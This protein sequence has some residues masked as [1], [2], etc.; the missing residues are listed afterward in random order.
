MRFWSE[1]PPILFSGVH[2]YVR[3]RKMDRKHFKPIKPQRSFLEWC[4]DKRLDLLVTLGGMAAVLLATI[5]LH[6]FAPASW[7]KSAKVVVIPPGK[8]FHEV[9]RILED[10]G[11]IR[12]R[13][14][15]Y[16]LARIEG[17][18]SRVKA[19][20][21]EVHT[22]MPPREVLSKLVR[23]EVIQ[24]PVTIPE[25]YNL[26]QIG[27]VLEQAK[28]C[29]KKIFLEKVRDPAFIDSLGL[30]G[31]SLEGYL[32]P[33]TYNL[34]KGFGEEQ[35]IRQMAARFKTVYA[36][37]AK[38]AEKL[39]L[40]RLDVVILAS[41]IEK[42]AKD[43]RCRRSWGSKDWS[44]SCA[45]RSPTGA[46][47]RGCRRASSWSARRAP[48]R[49]CWRKRSPARP[50]CRSSRSPAPNSSRCSW[51]SVLR[52][53]ATSSSRPAKLHLHRFHRRTR[54]AGAR[55]TSASRGGREGADAQSALERTRRFRSERGRPKPPSCDPQ[56]TL[57]PPSC[58]PQAT[59][60]LQ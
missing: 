3:V 50:V 46:W 1:T 17:E 25:G 12:D 10:N 21:Y 36:S 23:G 48:A 26:Y 15:F 42:E 40:S 2:S 39:G 34:P 59:P 37:L 45:I 30:E 47:G 28:V 60:R 7:T 11:I 54:R 49:R 41:M 20:E 58:D 29:S 44:P 22:Q 19:G 35:V 13:R 52:V 33:D 24:Y 43:R 32:F 51:A 16:L 38:R 4:K 9:A 5:Y 18:V 57:K 56:A 55:R 6:F 27:E 8:S 14:S 53:C 31:D